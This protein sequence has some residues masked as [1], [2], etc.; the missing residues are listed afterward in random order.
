MSSTNGSGIPAE[1]E[2]R[3]AS[4]SGETA[5]SN[6]H[7][8]PASVATPVLDEALDDMDIKIAITLDL[9]GHTA[10]LANVKLDRVIFDGMDHRNRWEL[11][12]GLRQTLDE[13]GRVAANKVKGKL[14]TSENLAKAEHQD[15]ASAASGAVEKLP[16]AFVIHH[17]PPLGGN[18]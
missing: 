5:A 6:G 8:S 17:P 7:C 12:H 10:K 18:W 2:S 14:S 11:L 3:P 9:Q 4:D 16:G 1:L 13:L 15:G